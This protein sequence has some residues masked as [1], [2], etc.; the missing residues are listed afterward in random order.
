[1]EIIKRSIEILFSPLGI[2]SVCMIAGI[3]LWN[4]K[5]YP[6]IARR[7]L[8]WGGCLFLIFLFSPLSKYLI[9]SLE[10]PF[11]PLLVPPESLKT[12]CIVVLA[13][14]AEE[15]PGLP[16]TSSIS[17]QTIY[18]LSEG[19]RLYRLIP[20]SSIILSGGVAPKGEK[21]IAASMADFL[22]QMGVPAENLIVEGNSRST[23]EN[24]GEVRK[25]V[26]SDPFILVAS[27]CDLKRA[28]GVARKL[29]MKPIPAPAWIWTLQ[30]YPDDMS[31]S[32][33]IADF[34]TCFACPSTDNLFRLQWAY[35][36]YAGYAWYRLL[37]RI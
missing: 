6:H 33:W 26:G 4:T 8:Y 22:R 19:L 37:G 30:H 27:A 15:F 21:S 28:V 5:R 24:L 25:V 32:D 36:E 34:F 20:E 35:H 7:L 29:K 9:L 1:M 12:E 31:F 11:P 16:I 14:Y 2:V 13:G 17:E 18:S 23:F 10:R 3:V